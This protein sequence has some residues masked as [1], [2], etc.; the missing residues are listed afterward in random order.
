MPALAALLADE[1]LA[2]WARI[3]LEA[4]PGPE[5]D[6]ALREAMGKVEGRLLIGVINSIGVRRDAEA[7]DGLAERLKDAD[8]DVASA[9][10]VALGQIG[11]A[12]ATK[13]LRASRWPAPPPRSARRSPKGASCVPRRLLA[14][15]KA[16]EAAKLYDEVRK[17]DVPK[18]RVVEAT[19]G[20]I[21]ARQSAGVP[22]LVEQLRVGRQGD[23]R[24]RAEHGPRAS[25]TRS[26]RGAGGR[27][28]QGRAGAAGPVDP[29]PGRP[30]R[31]RP[32]CPPCSKR[33]RAAR[34]RCGSRPSACCSA[35]ATSPAC[36]RCWTS[37]SRRTRNWPQAAKA[38]LE[39][40]PGDG[41]RRRP[42][43]SAG[44]GR[45][46]DRVRC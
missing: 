22:L 6:E 34:A 46:Q 2:S 19:R 35:W 16:D 4:I 30:R 33:P 32:C 7:V 12:P 38:A 1:E 14:E 15:G 8:A 40:L 39:G 3:A 44:E 10:A 27:A 41:R 42:G 20:A 45:G 23:V 25:G 26:D 43:R 17:A 24:H 13:I 36:P 18:Q 5:A 9:A 29:R 31:R 37:R 28:G 21:L 11:N